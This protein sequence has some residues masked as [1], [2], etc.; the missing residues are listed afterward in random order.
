MGSEC[1]EIRLEGLLDES[2]SE[3]FAGLTIRNKPDETILTGSLRDQAVL[4]GVLARVRDLNLR[5]ISVRRLEARAEGE[6]PGEGEK[7]RG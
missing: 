3:E 2:W 1:Y 7:E 6:A 5:L 4:H